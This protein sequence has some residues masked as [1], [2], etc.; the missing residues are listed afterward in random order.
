MIIDWVNPDFGIYG[1]FSIE[2]MALGRPVICSLTDS[3]YENYDLPIISINPAN[4]AD[5]NTG[6]IKNPHNFI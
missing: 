2:S 4:L 3:L 5:K 6:I 1:V